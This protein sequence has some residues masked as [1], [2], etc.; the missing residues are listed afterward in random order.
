MGDKDRLDRAMDAYKERG[1]PDLICL[2]LG[3]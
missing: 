2:S 3:K 1:C